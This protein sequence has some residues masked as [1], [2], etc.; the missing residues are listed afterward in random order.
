MLTQVLATRE[1][2]R[3]RREPSWWQLQQARKAE[4]AAG[5]KAALAL[6]DGGA[7]EALATT[8]AA[9]PS[10]QPQP[11]SMRKRAGVE[12]A[13][14]LPVLDQQ[15]RTVAVVAA[16]NRLGGGDDG[17]LFGRED[18]KA[19]AGLCAQ[20]S[21]ALTNLTRRP[22]EH[23]SLGENLELLAAH[24]A[25][26]LREYRPTLKALLAGEADKE[27]KAGL[28]RTDHIVPIPIRILPSIAAAAANLVP[29]NARAPAA[30]VIRDSLV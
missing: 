6:L 15:G 3:Y 14:C 17:G 20:T 12:S 2:L 22:E 10:P 9:P 25:L 1:G 18:A 11:S 30:P 7:T 24:S 19:L 16:V 26:P 28:V 5:A 8:T 4:E 29:A 13:L 21:E 23:V 27:E